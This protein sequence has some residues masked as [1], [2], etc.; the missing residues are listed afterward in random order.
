M[1]YFVSPIHLFEHKKACTERR[2]LCI[3]RQQNRCCP[4]R[5]SGGPAIRRGRWDCS[6]K[7]A[8]PVF[9]PAMPP[10]GVTGVP[11]R[12]IAAELQGLR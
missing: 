5:I 9:V 4:V 10:E 3:S 12:W 6:T 2:R 11:C 7:N 8:I 1:F